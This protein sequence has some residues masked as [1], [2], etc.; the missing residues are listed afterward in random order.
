MKQDRRVTRT[1][2]LLRDALVAL[3]LE[4]GYENIY[5]TDITDRANV[6]RATFYLHFKDK[7]ELLTRSLYAVFDEL[8]EQIGDLTAET[9]MTFDAPMRRAP[10][11]HASR[12]RDLYRVA[13]ISK[14]SV[15]AVSD[16]VREYVSRQIERQLKNILPADNQRVPLPIVANYIA[17]AQLAMISWWLEQDEGAYSAA[18]MAEMLYWLSLPTIN[19]LIGLGSMPVPGGGG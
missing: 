7:E 11:E 14:H 10:F 1:R 3:I 5:V 15:P 16:S 6:S 2:Q 17:G 18:Y 13:L 4:K 9:L 8:V 19:Q 12:H